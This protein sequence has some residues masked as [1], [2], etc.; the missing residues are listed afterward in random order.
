MLEK[1]QQPRRTA[2]VASRPCQ[3]T[4]SLKRREGACPTGQI[5]RVIVAALNR[6]ER[7]REDKYCG[8]ESCV[9]M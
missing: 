7:W 3:E 5:M 1:S 9:L 6:R 4:S 2:Q 8:Q